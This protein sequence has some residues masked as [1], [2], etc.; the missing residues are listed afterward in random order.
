MTI[1]FNNPRA[2]PFG[3]RVST[4]RDNSGNFDGRALRLES[5]RSERGRRN[6]EIRMAEAKREERMREIE[7]A[8]IQRIREEM[9][10]VKESDLPEEKMRIQ[11]SVLGE[12][13]GQIYTQRAEREQLA[14][15]RE[16]QR[17][18][19]ENEERIR[20]REEAAREQAIAR[21][22]P[23]QLERAQEDMAIRSMTL[24]GIRMDTINAMSRTRATMS[25]EAQ[26]LE[27]AID[28]SYGPKQIGLSTTLWLP[29]GRETPN[30]FRNRHL[31]D[32]RSGI[33]RLD[34]SIMAQVSAMYRD[35][36]A[37][38]DAQLG[39]NRAKGFQTGEDSETNDARSELRSESRN[40]FGNN[41]G[42]QTNT[43]GSAASYSQ[44][45]A[46]SVDLRL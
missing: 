10:R 41:A 37:L 1:G 21:K 29:T 20:E 15:E 17:Q 36:Q 3:A 16:M 38:Q 11:L 46:V 39:I 44:G 23:E 26:Q 27:T 7:N 14:M 42:Y 6:E 35:S 31:Q 28:N 13:I 5:Q 22:T 2:T 45:G 40:K 24:I 30:D 19:M 34:A 32:L 4:S 18:Q 8:W 9:D 43:E 33:A 25:A 12:Q